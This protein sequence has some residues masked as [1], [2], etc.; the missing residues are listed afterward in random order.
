METF[1]KKAFEAAVS[2]PISFV[3]DNFS[4]S[5]LKNTIRGLHYQT[6]PHAQGKLVRCARGRLLDVA[7]DIRANS[8]T[9][10]HWFSVELT[11][12]NDHQLWIPAGFLHGFRTLEPNTEIAYKCT[13][14]Y[15]P[16]CDAAILW[17]DE[18]LNID[19][20]LSEKDAVLSEKDRSA[21]TFDGF[22]TPF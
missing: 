18:T 17:N 10:G 15:S 4:L 14:Y 13:D 7:V 19:W 12:K 21:P 16:E 3:Q 2:A 20:G 11:E 22:K 9:Y 8:L 5:M 6:P 1:K